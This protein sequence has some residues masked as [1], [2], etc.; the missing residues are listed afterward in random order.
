MNNKEKILENKIRDL[1]GELEALERK[2]LRSDEKVRAKTL[3]RMQKRT[4]DFLIWLARRDLEKAKERA[5][6]EQGQ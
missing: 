2:F 5:P 4:Q 6:K 1:E 3:L